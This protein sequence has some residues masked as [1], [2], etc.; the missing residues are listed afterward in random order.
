M[1]KH[2]ETEDLIQFGMIPEFLGRLPVV[3]VL[4]PLGSTEL[5]RVLVEPKN[6]I[7]KQYQRMFE[8]EGATLRF[9][10]EALTEVATQALKRKTGVRAL[11]SIIEGLLRETAFTL[12]ETGAGREFAITPEIARGEKPL[13]PKKL[14]LRRQPAEREEPPAADQ[15][16]PA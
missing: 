11:R 14:P 3:A 2:V 12:P 6:A 8:M 15:K 10:E 9:T 16:H 1:M 5:R 13:K 4:D 7:I